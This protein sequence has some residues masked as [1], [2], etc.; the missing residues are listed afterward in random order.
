MAITNTTTCHP[1]VSDFPVRPAS[2]DWTLDERSVRDLV[3]I[4]TLPAVWLGADPLRVAESLAAA[5]CTTASPDFVYVCLKGFPGLGAIDVAQ[6]GRYVTDPEIAR[7]IGPTILQWAS[8]RDPDELVL[9]SPGKKLPEMRITFRPLGLHGECGVVAAGFIAADLP[10]QFHKILLDITATQATVAVQSLQSSIGERRAR[11]VAESLNSVAQT[12]A[13]DL[14][15]EGVVQKA[16]DAAT[17]LTGAQFGAFFYNTIDEKGESYLLYT[18]SGVPRE[19]FAKFGLPRNTPLFEPTFRGVGVLRSDDILKHPSYG[20]NPPHHGMPQGH[21]P[22]RSYLAVPVLSRSGDVLGGLFFGHPQPAVF[23]EHSEKLAVGIAAQA[24]I[25]ID[26]AML[27]EQAQKEISERKRIQEALRQAHQELEHHAGTLEKRVAERTVRLQETIAELEAFSYSISHDLRSPL[28][29]I[30]GYAAVL[31]A[32]KKNNLDPEALGYVSK[33][34]RA[35][36]RMDMLIRDVLAYSKVAKEKIQ[37]APV[38]VPPLIRDIVEQYPE[39]REK[40]A[41][42]S[43]QSASAV[44]LGSEA[45]LTQC[46]SN[47]LRN[48][49][50]FVA[51]G[52][53]PRCRFV[54]RISTIPRVFPFP[55]TASASLLS[56]TSKSLKSLVEST[57]TKCMKALASG[58]PSSEK[59]SSAWAA[60]SAFTPNTTKEAPSGSL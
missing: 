12:L 55:I 29:S 13:A 47:L 4:S 8:S 43:V 45:Y 37:L 26:N 3:A 42:I 7:E 20:Q 33:M 6:T 18:L 50:K 15:L 39:F 25:A 53:L 51:P 28:R 36:S 14:D 52:V 30:A 22:V 49:V 41:S 59:P 38:D 23:T 35:A 11:E 32:D 17:K 40:R 58:S 54:S 31:L 16:T 60:P 21:L 44:V 57:P 10:N 24:A 5:L 27:Y 34:E 1:L 46:I 2:S 48:A 9:A 19:A 56:T